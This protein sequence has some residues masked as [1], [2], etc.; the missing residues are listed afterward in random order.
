M[1]MEHPIQLAMMLN[2]IIPHIPKITPPTYIMNSFNPVCKNTS[3]M[4]RLFFL[5]VRRASLQTTRIVKNGPVMA[6]H[7]KYMAIVSLYSARGR[8]PSSP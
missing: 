8:G 4:D 7:A 1:E 5:M 6:I 2:A 3:F